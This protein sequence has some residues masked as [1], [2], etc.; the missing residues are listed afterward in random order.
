M[1]RNF[2]VRTLDGW[3]FGGAL[4]IPITECSLASGASEAGS[5]DRARS[6]W[7]D[8]VLVLHNAAVSWAAGISIVVNERYGD[9][10][11]TRK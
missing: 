11:T 5:G 6:G 7:S 4:G 10:A 8:A 3:C 1:N 9:F 2:S